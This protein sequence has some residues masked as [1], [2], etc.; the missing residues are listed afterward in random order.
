MSHDI[1]KIPQ[2]ARIGPERRPIYGWKEIKVK[3]L[4]G[5]AVTKN[6]EVYHAKS[7]LKIGMLFA[8]NEKTAIENVKFV[9]S[10]GFDWSL[11]ENEVVENLK[12]NPGIMATM[13]FIYA[14]TLD[15]SLI[16]DCVYG[17]QDD[18]ERK[19]K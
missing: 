4:N 15:S 9:S 8:K 13:N 7:G 14:N 12:K 16:V 18:N 1:I 17:T 11:S 2:G 5:L 10:L 3:I 6:G 19:L